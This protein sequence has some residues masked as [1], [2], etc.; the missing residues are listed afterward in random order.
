M[1]EP[2]A[3]G[4]DVGGTKL[5]AARIDAEGQV[6][7]RQRRQSPT[8]DEAALLEL[9]A[10][11]VG[12]LD[13]G[14]LPVGIGVAGI[15]APDGTLRYGPNLEIEDV[16][17]AAELGRELEVPVVV[18]NDATAAVYG[19]YRAGAGRGV[20]HV[21]MVTLGTGVG[22]AAVIDGQVL[23]GAHGFAGEFG[24]I[25]IVENGR[26]CP[27][28]NLGCLEAYASGTAI[29]LR[30]AQRLGDATIRTSL[31]EV[32]PE[33]MVGKR[34]TEAANDG[35]AFAQE[36]LTEAGTWLGI[37]LASLVNVLDPERVLVGGG[38]VTSSA[39]WVLPAARTAM[40]AR[41]IG[42]E[43]RSLPDVALAE[44]GDD[45]GMVGAALL[46]AEVMT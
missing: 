5:T 22:G 1:A 13:G 12:D 10:A 28:G 27:C 34:V 11:L 3:I 24:H 39:A 41:I 4:I 19:E 33:E 42:A 21:L 32:A 45:A 30:A 35:D 9:L 46:A 44:L 31:R 25:I 17:I 8:G 18:K 40:T 15:V 14:G 2:V 16:A 23:D 6:A 43:H 7:D 37:G 20:E 36:V 26:P 29:G 38:A